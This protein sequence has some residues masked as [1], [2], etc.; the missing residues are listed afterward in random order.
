MSKGI[1]LSMLNEFLQNYRNNTSNKKDKNISYDYQEGK[2]RIEKI[3]NSKLKIE[4]RNRLTTVEDLPYEDSYKS[5]ITAIFVDIR[6][7][8]E[9]FKKDQIMVSKMIKSFTSEVITILAEN[10]N[11][12]LERG[13][14]GDCVY[15]VYSTPQKPDIDK[16]LDMAYYIN[17]LIDMLN[18]LFEKNSYPKIQIGI[19][20]STSQELIIKAGRYRDDHDENIDNNAIVWIGEAVSRASKLSSFGNK[21]NIDPIVISKTTYTNISEQNQTF[22]K[23][24]DEGSSTVYHGSVR[25]T[26]F[27]KWIQNGMQ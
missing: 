16:I 24:I 17:T 19:G 2:K 7:S 11:N 10:N 20:V 27:K 23:K 15:A 25:K 6:N 14:R 3:L 21:N 22:F 26:E 18:K 1:D 8:A 5:W 9:L 4:K 12:C 13:I